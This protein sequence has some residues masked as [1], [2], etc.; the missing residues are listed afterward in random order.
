MSFRFVVWNVEKFQGASTPRI[1]QIAD[2]IN[3]DRP[4][5][6]GILEFQAKDAARRLITDFYG[7]YDFAMTDS[8]MQLDIFIGWR[9]GHFEQVLYTQR[10]DFQAGN[11]NLRPGGLL[12]FRETGQ[13]AFTNML[14]LH[15]DSGTGVNDYNARQVMFGKI[16]SLKGAL[17][18]LPIQGG[19]ARLI[20]LGDLNTMG[21]SRTS[22]LPT[23]R[24]A[25]EIAQL[26]TDAAAAGMRMLTKSHEKTWSNGGNTRTSNLDHVVASSDLSFD[27]FTFT[28]TPAIAADNDP[29]EVE[30]DGWN[31][32]TGQARLDWINSVSD[33]CA[34]FG[35]VQ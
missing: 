10:R 21:R 6:F 3:A 26:E 16:W 28:G 15:T 12:S 32:R 9:R 22:T 13:S 20:A 30:V 8:K 7:E 31:N 14:F 34:L 18:G 19:S 5:V 35:A 23:I 29:F 27:Q 1:G 17:E 33:H 2:H 25:D 24:A 4:E 11:I